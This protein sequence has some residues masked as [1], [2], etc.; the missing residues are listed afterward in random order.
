MAISK[1]LYISSSKKGSKYASLN[2]AI[3]YISN[4]EKTESGKYVST[5]NCLKN[6]VLDDMIMTKEVHGKTDKRQG[7]HVIVSFPEGETDREKAFSIIGDFAKEY[8]GDRFEAVYSLHTNTDI[9]H[10][11]II[12]NSVSFFDGYKYRYENGDWEKS[13]QP[14]LDEICQKYG[15]EKLE[16][17]KSSK[18]PRNIKN[19]YPEEKKSRNK[20]CNEKMERF[21]NWSEYIKR[22]FDEIIS[23]ANSFDEVINKLKEYGYEVKTDRKHIAIKPPGMNRFRRIDTE[24]MKGYSKPEIEEKIRIRK[25]INGGV[26]ISK[27]KVNSNYKRTGYNR[28]YSVMIYHKINVKINYKPRNRVVFDKRKQLI[29]MGIIKK[30]KYSEIYNRKKDIYD[31]I[32]IWQEYNLMMRAQ[33]TSYHQLT[34]LSW[35]IDK[36]EA[37]RN[38]IINRIKS[39]SE[40]DT[41]KLKLKEELKT[42]NKQL[43]ADKKTAARLENKYAK[44]YYTQERK[45]LN[46]NESRRSVSDYDT[47]KNNV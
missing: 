39:V 16:Y 37:V 35:F 47:K 19:N 46:I 30:K 43:K 7:Y 21:T 14:R 22:D 40:S 41:V 2:N 33:I 42:I 9:L 5:I 17:D 13:M 20:Y 18:C 24:M 6:T 26:S 44:A 1:I 29:R 32:Y 12:F 15:F 3:K 23:T 10:G 28:K 25:Q 27:K 34:D 8:F 4:P 11:H 45:Y 31:Y 38:E 36:E